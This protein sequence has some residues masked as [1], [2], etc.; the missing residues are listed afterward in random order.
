MASTPTSV[1]WRVVVE[2]TGVDL[3]DDDL[4]E[5]LA[6]NPQMHIGLSSSDF[7]TTAD[8]AV[9]AASFLDAFNALVDTVTAAAPEAGVLRLVDPLVTIADIADDAGV[10]RQAVRNWALGLRQ[11]GF[12]RPLAIVG[13]GVRVW[14]QADVDAWLHEAMNLGSG[15]RFASASLIAQV[16][17]LLDQELVDSAHGDGDADNGDDGWHVASDLSEVQDRLVVR[18]PSRAGSARSTAAVRA[19]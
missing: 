3:D 15:Q 8:A 1:S 11:S 17:D 4:V 18:R 13:D 2:F 10:T 19:R 7:V 14:R 6:S 9:P 16:N 5:A 12:P